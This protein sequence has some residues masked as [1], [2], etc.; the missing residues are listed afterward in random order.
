MP[1]R[2]LREGNR[3]NPADNS[4]WMLTLH[5]RGDDGYGALPSA[6]RIRCTLGEDNGEE[7]GGQNWGTFRHVD[8]HWPGRFGR[9]WQSKSMR[10]LRL[11]EGKDSA[12]GQSLHA[13]LP[14]P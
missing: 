1:I 14:G 2:V 7:E 5:L 10:A 11:R 13:A 12:H 9:A 8:R 4:Q 3:V 6:L